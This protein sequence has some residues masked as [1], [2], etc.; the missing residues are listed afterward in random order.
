MDFSWRVIVFVA[1][2]SLYLY[3]CTHTAPFRDSQGR[4][5][6]GSIAAME[7]LP[8]GG[9][10]QRLWFRG[11]DMHKPALLILHG[12]PGVSEAALYRYFDSEL[13]QHFLVVNWEQRGTGRSFHTD[14]SPESM[15]IAQF[16]RDLDDVVE[17]IRKRFHKETVVLLGESWGT[18]LGTSYAFQHPEK[19]AAYVGIGQV[20][21]MPEGERL[22][23]DYALTQAMARGQE[24]AIEELSAIGSPPH[25]VDEMLISRRW[26]ERF[27]GS[28]HAD[29][30]TGKLIWAA[31][32]TDEANLV[33]LFLFGRGNRF[34]LEHL[35]P[36]FFRF[37]LT[38]YKTFKM[39]V[40]FLLGRYDWQVPA[41]LA[42]SYFKTIEAPC[43]QLV[44]FERSAHH[45]PFEQPEEF[46]RVMIEDVLPASTGSTTCVKQPESSG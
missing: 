6:P 24:K 33:D 35:W 7:T 16:L 1:V 44:W 18:A 15:T 2:L 29:L 31:L 19:I 34:S 37:D 32:N 22:S 21:N 28:F 13:E 14:I 41:I 5:V 40:F 39:P 36:E 20:V 43:K 12:G 23:Y 42:A 11:I 46:N 25:T 30:S 3:G 8:I 4:I 10:P 17:L 38:V 9:I 27:G 45:P 26:V